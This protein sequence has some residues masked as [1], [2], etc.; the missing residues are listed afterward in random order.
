MGIT[1]Y[2]MRFNYYMA[3]KDQLVN[4]YH[5]EFNEVQCHKDR[6]D[7]GHY[8]YPKYPTPKDIF[9]LAEDIKAFAEKK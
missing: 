2:E 7:L 9:D 1:P 5:A 8:E 6:N 4:A 3:A